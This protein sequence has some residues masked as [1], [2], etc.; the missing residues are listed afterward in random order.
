MRASALCTQSPSSSQQILSVFGTGT[1]QVE[2]A[3][4][5]VRAACTGAQCPMKR[6]SK[7]PLTL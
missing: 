5:G 3:L 1:E 7:G 4:G 6:D 2:T